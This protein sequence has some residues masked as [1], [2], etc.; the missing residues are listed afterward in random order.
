MMKIVTS[1]IIIAMIVV[2]AFLVQSCTKED[3]PQ[4]AAAAEMQF[5][6]SHTDF[7]YKDP[8]VVPE[9]SEYSM[10]YV[11][12]YFAGKMYTSPILFVNGEFLT[13][14]V[15]LIASEGT[16]EL[17]SFFVY[18]DLPPAGP[19]DDD[20][21]IMAAPLPDSEYHG[22]MENKL[23]IEVEVEAFKKKSI[24]IDVLCY[25][26]L[27]YHKFGFSWLEINQF[28][29][30]KQ[31]ISGDICV[32][33]NI[34]DYVGSPY[35]VQSGDVRTD[36]PAIMKVEVY[37]GDD[38]TRTFS[39]EATYDDNPI[40]SVHWLEDELLTGE[41]FT[42]KLYVLLPGSSSWTYQFVDEIS[43]LDGDGAL[44]GGNGIVDFVIGTCD[45]GNVD[46][47]FSHP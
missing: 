8:N 29:I 39:N 41:D 27:F 23:N 11:K 47:T 31:C 3:V 44:Q 32:G 37:K 22:L 14:S 38:L 25:E 33:Q 42:Y 12:F 10:D 35:G 26:S 40:L 20:M 36:L 1:V 30:L 19:D 21:L 5:S 13:K 24:T 2:G 16:Y 9:C 46:Y 45:V 4:R 18:H 34:G 6:I 15:K 43:F 7:D 28:R 17:S